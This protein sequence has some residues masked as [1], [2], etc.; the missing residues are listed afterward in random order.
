MKLDVAIR[1]EMMYLYNLNLLTNLILQESTFAANT[2]NLLINPAG[3][4]G[5]S[6]RQDPI[7][8][9]SAIDIS[10]SKVEPAPIISLNITLPLSL[11]LLTE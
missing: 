8:G 2:G 11:K 5:R 1:S 10:L 4:G 3:G 9:K 6:S 7:V